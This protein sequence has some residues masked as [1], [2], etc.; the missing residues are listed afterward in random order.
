VIL[1]DG[2]Q[3]EY[4]AIMAK[5]GNTSFDKEKN[6]ELYLMHENDAKWG[7]MEYFLLPGPNKMLPKCLL[8][9]SNRKKYGATDEILKIYK[10]DSF[11]KGDK[12]SKEALWK[13]IDF[14]KDALKK[15]KEWKVFEFDFLET[16]KYEDISQFYKDVEI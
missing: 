3:N 15:Y 6:K 12:F 9:K 5:G 2:A 16:Q 10:D 7:K 1:R 14:Y 11:K 8:P 4:L 13:L